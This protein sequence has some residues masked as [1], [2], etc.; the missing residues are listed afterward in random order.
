MYKTNFVGLSVYENENKIDDIENSVKYSLLANENDVI[1]NHIFFCSKYSKYLV[2][3]L[4]LGL[5][6]GIIY[7]LYIYFI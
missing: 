6:V 5:L 3:F 7:G 2:L 4:S 1:D